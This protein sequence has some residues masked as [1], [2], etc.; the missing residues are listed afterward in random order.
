MTRIFSPSVQFPMPVSGIGG[1][2]GC[3]HGS[4]QAESSVPLLENDGI[5]LTTPKTETHEDVA[6]RSI[7]DLRR[8]SRAYHVIFRTPVS[9]L[10]WRQLRAAPQGMAFRVRQSVARSAGERPGGVWPRGAVLLTE[11]ARRSASA[12]SYPDCSAGCERRHLSQRGFQG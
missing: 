6:L 11:S 9:G 10:E 2:V 12:R 4:R 3:Y 5:I 1:N 8:A 7:F